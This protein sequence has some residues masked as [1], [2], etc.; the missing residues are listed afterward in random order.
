ACAEVERPADADDRA[1][2]LLVGRGARRV[3]AAEADPGG[4]D[5]AEVD[6]VASRQVVEHGRHRPLVARLDVARE[7]GLPLPRPVERERREAPGE[8]DVLPAEELL[9]RRVETRQEQHARRS[10]P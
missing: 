4:A 8:E 3:I 10:A 1:Q 6:V 2:T 9:L 7:P 5:A